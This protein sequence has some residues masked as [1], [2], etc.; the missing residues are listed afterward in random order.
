ML[1]WKLGIEITFEIKI[2][3]SNLIKMGKMPKKRHVEES[4]PFSANDV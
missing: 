3:K 2:R 1:A 4:T